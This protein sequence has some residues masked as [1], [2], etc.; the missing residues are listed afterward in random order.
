[1]SEASP[2][3]LR[4]IESLQRLSELF[5]ERRR[6]L[7][8]RAGLT[9][10]QWRVLE[11]VEGEDFMPSMFARRRACTPAAVSR[12]LRQLLEG[13]LLRVS[14]GPADGRK[15]VYRLTARGRRR[16]AKLRES[17]ARAIEAIWQPFGP[18][19][20]AAFTRFAS[21]LADR[22]EEYVEATPGS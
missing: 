19:E 8:R 6:Q 2:D 5:A 12:T 22:L 10:T 1:V 4:A 7:A 9:E 15:R 17:R 11:E 21:E 20:L 18:T 16:L 13:D 3:S 14:I